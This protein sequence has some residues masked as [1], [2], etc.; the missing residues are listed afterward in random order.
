VR[1]DVDVLGAEQLLGALDREQLDLVHDLA[2][3]V[4]ALARVALGVLVGEQGAERFQ[5]R[6]A[7]E[8]LARNQLQRVAL[9]P[10]FLVD[11][12]GDGGVGLL[13]NAEVEGGLDHPTS[14]SL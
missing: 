4:V 9:A 1:L 7:G 5:D 2:P 12:G 14:L 11:E 10:V 6:R 3:A 8:V 13:Q